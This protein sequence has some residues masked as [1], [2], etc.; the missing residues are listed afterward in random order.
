M[1]ARNKQTSHQ[2]IR[3]ITKEQLS[4]VFRRVEG[5]EIQP[6]VSIPGNDR[7]A[8]AEVCSMVSVYERANT[9]TEIGSDSREDRRIQFLIRRKAW[10]RGLLK[11]HDL[12]EPGYGTGG[13]FEDRQFEVWIGPRKGVR[14][15]EL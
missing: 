14:I 3:R 7:T 9:G 15:R 12:S 5:P 10:A 1:S 11:K 6:R 13:R 2:W 8:P 4:E